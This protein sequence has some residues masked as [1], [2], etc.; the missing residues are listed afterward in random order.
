MARSLD[1]NITST[2]GSG[3]NPEV[4]AETPLGF[5]RKKGD[6]KIIEMLFKAGPKYETN[7]YYIAAHCT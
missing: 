6:R 1:I 5:A 7:T 4:I 2:A 3:H